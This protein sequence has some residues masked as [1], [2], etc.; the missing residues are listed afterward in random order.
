M[1]RWQGWSGS[2]SGSARRSR[3]RETCCLIGGREKRAG[4][5]G[6][7]VVSVGLVVELAKMALSR[8]SWAGAGRKRRIVDKGMSGSLQCHLIDV[9]TEKV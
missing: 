3:G 2:G 4:L 7:D 5:D 8:S 9:G 6:W 1:A